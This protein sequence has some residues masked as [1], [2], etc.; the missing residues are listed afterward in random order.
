MG[1]VWIEGKNVN[2]E[3][4]L[5]FLILTI[6]LCTCYQNMYVYIHSM[7]KVLNTN[8]FFKNRIIYYKIRW[9]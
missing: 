9:F 4:T 6:I 3:Q 8:I 5:S 1:C 2:T 7:L